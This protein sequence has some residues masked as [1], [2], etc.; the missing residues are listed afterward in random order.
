LNKTKE[1]DREKV[2]CNNSHISWSLLVITLFQSPATLCDYRIRYLSHITYRMVVQTGR[3]YDFDIACD[4]GHAIF[5][6]YDK[7]RIN[8]RIEPLIW[9]PIME[10]VGMDSDRNYFDYP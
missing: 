2:H 6:A 5:F 3:E 10:Q 9:A 8:S 4:T 7:Y 1:S